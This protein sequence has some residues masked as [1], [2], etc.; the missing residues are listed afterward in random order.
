M[1]PSAKSLRKFFDNARVVEPA[2]RILVQI[3]WLSLVRV[4]P[5]VQPPGAICLARTHAE[6]EAPKPR[7][8]RTLCLRRGAASRQTEAPGS[9]SMVETRGLYSGYQESEC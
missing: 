4:R 1:R 7:A 5:P 2:T 6:V 9:A 3:R 8:D